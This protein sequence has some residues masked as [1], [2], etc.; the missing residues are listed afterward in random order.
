M[1]ERC[2]AASPIPL[3]AGILAPCT[4]PVVLFFL[5]Q[6]CA[7][8]TR[9][10]DTASARPR[11]CFTHHSPRDSD[12]E[13]EGMERGEPAD[14]IPG[15]EHTVVEPSHAS[16]EPRRAHRSGRHQVG[17]WMDISLGIHRSRAKCQSN[18]N[19]LLFLPQCLSLRAP[20]EAVRASRRSVAPLSR[21]S[22]LLSSLE[23][24]LGEGRKRAH[25]PVAPRGKEVAR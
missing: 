1:N 19:P 3:L 22:A 21:R 16:H 12:D 25:T 7:L 6:G 8:R 23:Y 14:K 17:P 4:P 10:V 20:P 9:G 5:S 15:V 18:G 11:R 24:S 13:Q 2:A